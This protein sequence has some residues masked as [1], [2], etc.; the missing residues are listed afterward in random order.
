[1]NQTTLQFPSILELVDFQLIV[2]TNAIQ[3]NRVNLTL[4]GNFSDADIEFAKLSFRA[5]VVE[6][7]AN[8]KAK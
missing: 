5:A 6:D 2:E 7:P 1:M 8:L 3:L 4:T